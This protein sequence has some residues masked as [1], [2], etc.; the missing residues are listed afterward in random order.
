MIKTL[1]KLWEIITFPLS[2]SE[3]KMQKEYRHLDIVG[4]WMICYVII[5]TTSFLLKQNMIDT[6][7]LLYSAVE[8]LTI[9]AC[10]GIIHMSLEL[11]GNYRRS[12]ARKNLK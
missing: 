8:L 4:L 12:K 6:T 10:I 5:C 11:I 9:F 3:E 2:T 7:S 1:K